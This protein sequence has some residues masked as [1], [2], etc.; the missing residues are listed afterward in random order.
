VGE[1]VV[2]EFQFT[3]QK[4]VKSY[5]PNTHLN[6]ETERQKQVKTTS[7]VMKFA[8]GIRTY[9]VYISEGQENMKLGKPW[10]RR[11]V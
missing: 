1:E 11:T 6:R 7:S 8:V 10:N 2:H 9:T 3:T 4:T 5:I